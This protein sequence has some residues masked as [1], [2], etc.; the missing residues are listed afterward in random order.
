MCSN[1]LLDFL[2]WNKS[3]YHSV[4]PLCNTTRMEVVLAASSVDA[5]IGCWDLQTGAEQLRYKSCASSP[6]GLICVGG[7]FLASSQ[8]RDSSASSGFVFYWSWSKVFLLYCSSCIQV[9]WSFASFYWRSCILSIYLFRWTIT[10]GMSLLMA[11]Q[12]QVEVR[13][14]PAEPI[15]PLAAN[16]PGTYIAG[17]G[18]LG[19]IYLWEVYK[20]LSWDTIHSKSFVALSWRELCI[21]NENFSFCCYLLHWP[22]CFIF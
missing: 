16:H 1:N 6:H 9:V 8:L 7:R 22:A 18:L 4:P 14:F 17:G 2:C 19:D 21:I 12:P 10:I 5:G 13:S 15:K 11:L 3:S 20:L